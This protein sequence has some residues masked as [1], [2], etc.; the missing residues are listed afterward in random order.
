MIKK[1]AVALTLFAVM[2][3]GMVGCS[4]NEDPKPLEKLTLA[5]TPW[6]ASAPLYVAHERGYFRDEGLDVT[7]HPYVSGHLGLDAVLAGKAE[8]ATAGETPIALAAMEGKPLSVAATVCEIDRAILII[9]RK[10]RGISKPCDLRGR[11]VGV[12]EGTTAHFFLHIYLITSH[13]DPNDIIMVP[14]AADRVVDVLLNGEVDA[15]STWTPHTIMLL[16]RLGSNALV[17]HDANIYTM[18]WNLVAAQDFVKTHPGRIVKFLRAVVTANEFIAE[19]PEEAMAVVAA[20]IGAESPL[21]EKEWKDFKFVTVLEQSLIV[22]LEDQARWFRKRSSSKRTTPPDFTYFIHT[23]GLKAVR[24]EA[25][26]IT[27]T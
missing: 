12:V 22:N 4:R 24:P 18:T 20:A 13:V 10:D 14:I 6:P 17:L 2:L 7:L 5:V 26:G 23:D 21:F 15:V 16:D 3:V 1:G 19:K 9:A 25:V 8:L 11:R 27:G